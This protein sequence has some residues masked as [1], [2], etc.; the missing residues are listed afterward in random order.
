M[1]NKNLVLV[2]C[3]TMLSC[4]ESKQEEAEEDRREGE[5]QGDCRDGEDNDND[6]N[7]DC[8]D[9]GCKDK[10]IC[11]ETE[12]TDTD[13]ETEPDTAVDNDTQNDTAVDDTGTDSA[14]D[15]TGLDA[16]RNENCNDSEHT[17]SVYFAGEFTKNGSS[18]VG[19]EWMYLVANDAWAENGGYSCQLVWNV[20]GLLSE[21]TETC[22]DCDFSFQGNAQYDETQSTCQ[23][24]FYGEDTAEDFEALYNIQVAG[25]VTEWFYQSNGSF[26]ASGT[27]NNNQYSFLSEEYCSSY[28]ME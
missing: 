23:P 21:P 24:S 3:F 16:L 13:V 5:S 27:V 2:L 20:T 18:F 4:F 11:E 9:A 28:G 15:T 14:I 22:T 26:I 10:P 12:D 8:E 7:I 19:S 6:G 25:T 17:A 1:R